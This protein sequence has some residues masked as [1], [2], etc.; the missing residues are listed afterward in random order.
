MKTKKR[1]MAL[2]IAMCI[3][4]SIPGVCGWA[5]EFP[6]NSS[7]ISDTS[8]VLYEAQAGRISLQSSEQTV[9]SEDVTI[10]AST[11]ENSF[12]KY[13]NVG[14]DITTKDFQAAGFEFGDVV[15]LS[16]LNQTITVPYGDNFSNVDTGK[17]GIFSISGTD[18]LVIA[19]NMGNFAET[20][21]IAKK[22]TNEDKSYTWNY[23]EGVTAPVTFTISMKEKGGYLEEYTLRSLAYTDDRS[24]YPKLSDEEF[25]NFRPVQTTGMGKGVIYRTASPVNPLHNRNRYADAAIKKA[26]VTVIMNLADS[27]AELKGYEGFQDSYYAKQKYIPLDMG[28]DFEA[29]EFKT[30]LAKGLR[31]FADNP[32][33]YA[34]HCTEGKDRAG[35]VSAILECFMG[36]SYQ[37]VVSD[38]M[39]TYRNYYGV[40]PGEKRY[41]LI[42]DSNIVTSLKRAFGV[43][44]LSRSNLAK[45]AEE[46]IRKLGLSSKEISA[47]KKN[48]SGEQD[49][50]SA[51][52]KK[53]KIKV[54]RSFTRSANMK[55]AQSFKLKAS[56]NGAKLSYKSDKK[57][58]SVKNGKVTIKKGF[59]G[60][61]TI[62]ITSAK[63]KKYKSAKTTV[64]V[65]VNPLPTKISSVKPG[66]KGTATIKWKKN[67]SAKGYQIQYSTDK[68]FK[69][70]T[71]TIKINKG[72]VV[73]TTVKK[74]KNG[75]KYYFRIRTVNGK[76]V[77]DWSK[78][79]KVKAK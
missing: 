72:M 1:L 2:I 36:A 61:A 12:S 57:G 20:Y 22:T 16:F 27:E 21:K 9:S 59:V 31:F 18:N 14:I 15:T 3:S 29:K 75:K 25:A 77:S 42:A 63:T 49:K 6:G 60:K 64:T 35:F 74:L 4:M 30:K 51:D 70:N 19:I 11:V 39:V 54:S 33:V 17:E 5:S 45:E 76:I 28:V 56:A 38:Y 26:G 79:K 44:D 69:K 7:K 71:K 50:Q 65:T 8:S 40:E 62:K 55:K 10:T 32:G 23:W 58:V 68:K 52:L 13:G 37:E 66:K 41:Q 43:N 34:V 73:K 53:N 24:D 48:L 47:L 78:V 67:A 46:Y